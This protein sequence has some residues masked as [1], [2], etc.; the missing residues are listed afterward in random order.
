MLH[1]QVHLS[2]SQL[3]SMEHTDVDL[4]DGFE[5]QHRRSL[6]KVARK[7]NEK[8][9][10]RTAQNGALAA[11]EVLIQRKDLVSSSCR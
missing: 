3:V 1:M 6:A 4:R 2:G 7:V 10:G 9:R 5:G 8:T 11:T